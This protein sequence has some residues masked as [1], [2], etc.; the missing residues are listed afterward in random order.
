MDK[1]ELLGSRLGFIMLSV[2]T[3]LK[4]LEYIT[5]PNSRIFLPKV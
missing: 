3:E 4:Q 5:K 1:R 2:W